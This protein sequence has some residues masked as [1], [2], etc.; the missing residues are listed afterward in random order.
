MI[1]KPYTRDQ[2]GMTDI[3]KACED[4][5]LPYS[6]DTTWGDFD[7][8]L[9]VDQLPYGDEQYKQYLRNF[10]LLHSPLWKALK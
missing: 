3:D 7:R 2:W 10:P 5:D 4:H 8:Y 9:G 6:E 1:D